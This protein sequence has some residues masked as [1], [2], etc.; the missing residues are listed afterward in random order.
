MACLT[1][2]GLL[3]LLHF[4]AGADS[5]QSKL[6][7]NTSLNPIRHPVLDTGFG[8]FAR[9]SAPSLLIKAKPSI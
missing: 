5:A 8:Y 1:P 9:L 3:P 4:A 6:S 7:L 2:P